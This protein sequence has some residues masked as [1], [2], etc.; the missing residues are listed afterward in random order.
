MK[1]SCSFQTEPG[2]RRSEE[3]ERE[4]CSQA[5]CIFRKFAHIQMGATKGPDKFVLR[6]QQKNKP[7]KI[8]HDLHLAR[9]RSLGLVNLPQT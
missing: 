8:S 7:P 9:G 2:P 4:T 6:K 1:T 5:T 3:S